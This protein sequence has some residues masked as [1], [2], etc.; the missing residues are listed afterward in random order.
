MLTHFPYLEPKQSI[1]EEPPPGNQ[2]AVEECACT[3]MAVEYP[4]AA[5]LVAIPV[6]FRG[7]P[8][9]PDTGS[10]GFEISIAAF[11]AL[12]W[13][14]WRP[15]EF[16]HLQLIQFKKSIIFRAAASRYKC[17]IHHFKCKVGYHSG[18]RCE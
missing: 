9:K 15:S 16:H 4:A 10:N 11:S 13:Y 14:G 3:R 1:G 18:G 6:M 12:T 7:I 17:K 8:A 2:V 5:S